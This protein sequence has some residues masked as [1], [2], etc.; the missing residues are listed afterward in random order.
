MPLQESS[1]ARANNFTIHSTTVVQYQ[2]SLKSHQSIEQ[3]AV[4]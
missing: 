2:L 4:D 1:Q 3:T